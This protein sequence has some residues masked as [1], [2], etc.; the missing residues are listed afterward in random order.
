[1]C[2]ATIEELGENVVMSNR[3]EPIDNECDAPL[4]SFVETCETL[5]FRSPLD[6]RWCRISHFVGD[7]REPGGG[8]HP[9]RWLFGGIK[10]PVKTC[11]CG[12]PLPIMEV[13]ICTFESRK[14]VHY[15][16][17]QCRRCR[18]MFWE[19]VS[20]PSQYKSGTRGI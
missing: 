11:T 18:T 3:L 17:G 19:D 10:R 8:F 9:L 16:L 7:Q 4:Y 20:V 12:Q 6:V 5:G 2:R 14:E 15:L 1:V 13:C